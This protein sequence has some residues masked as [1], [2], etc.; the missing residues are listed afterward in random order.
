MRKYLFMECSLAEMHSLSIEL[1]QH[2]LDLYDSYDPHHLDALMKLQS[3]VNRIVKQIE[4]NKKTISKQS[5]W[6]S[7]EAIIE[8]KKCLNYCI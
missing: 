5:L 4:E 8:K 6:S 2:F 7:Y 3:T 1:I